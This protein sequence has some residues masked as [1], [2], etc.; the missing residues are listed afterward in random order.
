MLITRIY[1]V[2]HGATH[3]SQEDRFAGSADIDLSE[4][5]LR[6]FHVALRRF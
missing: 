2:R 6:L 5:G 4:E 3:A 1:L